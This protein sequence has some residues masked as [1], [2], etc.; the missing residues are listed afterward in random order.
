MSAIGSAH[1]MFL[2]VR[3]ALFPVCGTACCGRRSAFWRVRCPGC[4]LVMPRSGIDLGGIRAP[5]SFL[6]FELSD[7]WY[8][9]RQSKAMDRDGVRHFPPLSLTARLRSWWRR[10]DKRF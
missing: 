4:H 8:R 2:A 5:G 3:N 10:D 9:R 7:W 6:R 1:R